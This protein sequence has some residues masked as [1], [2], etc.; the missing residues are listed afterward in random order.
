[1]KALETRFVSLL[2]RHHGALLSFLFSDVWR[3]SPG[4]DPF[5]QNTCGWTQFRCL[6]T[7]SVT[8]TQGDQWSQSEDRSMRPL[9]ISRLMSCLCWWRGEVRRSQKRQREEQNSLLVASM[10]SGFFTDGNQR[11]MMTVRTPRGLL[12]FLW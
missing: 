1:M 3:R 2:R 12:R 9:S 8:T 6:V 5:D 10:D 11:R 4:A 7:I